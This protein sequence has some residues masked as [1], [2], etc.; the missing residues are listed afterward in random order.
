MSRTLGSGGLRLFVESRFSLLSLACGPNPAPRFQIPAKSGSNE[1]EQAARSV[2]LVGRHPMGHERVGLYARGFPH[3]GLV[4][5]RPDG[6]SIEYNAGMRHGQHM[7]P[8]LRFRQ[9]ERLVHK[10][11]NCAKSAGKPFCTAANSLSMTLRC[12][13]APKDGLLEDRT[14]AC[15]KGCRDCRGGICRWGRRT[16]RHGHQRPWHES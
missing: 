6:T 4:D 2:P 15:C 13:N 12:N 16:E 1:Q 11:S 7:L 10:L 14:I 9:R 3:G 8:C 5:E